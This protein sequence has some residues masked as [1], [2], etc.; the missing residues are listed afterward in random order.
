MGA[1]NIYIIKAERIE[2]YIIGEYVGKKGI[3]KEI[4]V[5]SNRESFLDYLTDSNYISKLKKR[6]G[7][8][9][10]FHI[11]LKDKGLIETIKKDLKSSGFIRIK[12]E[13]ITL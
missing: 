4:D 3:F 13:N 10:I 6:G 7:R 11:S 8:R 9:V 2:N 1:R 12:E 5:F